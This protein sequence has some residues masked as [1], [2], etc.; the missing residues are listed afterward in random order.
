MVEQGSGS[1][2]NIASTAG[3]EGVPPA[4]LTRPPSTH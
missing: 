1:I 3:I 4:R 2:I